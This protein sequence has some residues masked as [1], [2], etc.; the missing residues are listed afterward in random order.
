M[1]LVRMP[2]ILGYLLA[3][4][5]IGPIGLGFVRTSDEIATVS[6]IGLI[7]LLFMIGLEIDLGKMLASGRLVLVTGVLQFPVSLALGWLLFQGAALLGW[8]PG[9]GYAALYAAIATGISST[10]VVVKLLY[11]KKEL[12]TLPGR[13]TL[14]ILV[15]QD[16]WAIIILALQPNF[17]DPQASTI[18]LTFGAGA[19]LVVAALLASRFVLPRLFR[20]SAMAP[21]LMLVLALGWCF[22]VAM[23][24]AS[25][26]IGLSMEMGALIAGVSLATFPYNIDVISKV[27]SIRDFFI[28]LFFVALGMR[29]P[30]PTLGVLG[31]A[32]LLV[33]WTVVG[34]FLTV[35]VVQAFLKSGH[36]TGLVVTV[37]LTQISEFALVILSLGVGFGHLG[38]DA[39]PPVIWAFATMAVLSTYLVN[40]SHRIQS[41][42]SRGLKAM[43]ISDVGGVEEVYAGQGERPIILLGFFRE[44]SALVWEMQDKH[45]HFLEQIAVIDFNPEVHQRLAELGIPCIYGDIAHL[46]TIHHAAVDNARLVISSVPDVFLK[47]TNNLKMLKM[48]KSAFPK[49][50]VVVT[51]SSTSHALTLYQEGADF[52]LLPSQGAGESLIHMLEQGM[53]GGFTGFRE[54]QRQILLKRQ[55]ILT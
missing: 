4:L 11:E 51:A 27:I 18:L 22:L 19:G 40:G 2:L 1:K 23:V 28:T 38:Q 9:A 24:A 8:G 3:G 29:I 49:A 53:H 30:L 46:D 20:L 45:Q 26:V 35:F 37:N 10:M 47:G 42:I 15:F 39:M 41:E 48:A 31:V 43:G 7:L 44:A 50:Q 33:L 25:P 6:Q 17:S 14:G 21:E 34:R 5:T 32:A 55:E 52:V 12:D 16:I 13:I 54:Q 36:R